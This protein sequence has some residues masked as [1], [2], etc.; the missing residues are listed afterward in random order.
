MFMATRPLGSGPCKQPCWMAGA[1]SSPCAPSMTWDRWMGCRCTAPPCVMGDMKVQ[2]GG[3]GPGGA[4]PARDQGTFSGAIPS[5]LSLPPMFFSPQYPSIP[6]QTHGSPCRALASHTQ[7]TPKPTAHLNSSSRV[8]AAPYHFPELCHLRD[9]LAGHPDSWAQA[10][11]VQ[12]ACPT[13]T[14][15]RPALSPQP[16]AKCNTALFPSMS[17]PSSPV[18]CAWGLL[19]PLVS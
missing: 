13:S 8:T 19:H 10:R 6:G 17:L 9:C 5:L 18:A 1:L 3:A 2:Q 12:L 11:L 15:T 14:C 7:L 4:L 16:D